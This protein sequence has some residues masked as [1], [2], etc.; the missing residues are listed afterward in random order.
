MQRL[1]EG[2]FCYHIYSQEL[3]GVISA[4]SDFL[5]FIFLILTLLSSNSDKYKRTGAVILKIIQATSSGWQSHNDV[6]EARDEE[7]KMAITRA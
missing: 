7:F 1:S 4:P 2:I 5:F 3:K 6:G